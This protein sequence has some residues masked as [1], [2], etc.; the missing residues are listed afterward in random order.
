MG[1]L[2]HNRRHCERRDQKTVTFSLVTLHRG[3]VE[4]SV[5]IHLIIFQL[6]IDIGTEVKYQNKMLK[7]MVRIFVFAEK[8]CEK[9]QLGSHLGILDL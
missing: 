7:D 4:N 6:S 1:K 8:R 5:L 2:L 9:P 3:K